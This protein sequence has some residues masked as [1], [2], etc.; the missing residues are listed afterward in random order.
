MGVDLTADAEA[1]HLWPSGGGLEGDAGDGPA[2]GLAEVLEGR[3]EGFDL[4]FAHR[5][6]PRLARAST[7][8]MRSLI[9]ET[10]RMI[11]I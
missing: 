11:S 1:D 4:A 7:T 6:Q 10:C 2:E 5:R 9:G 8:A 3:G